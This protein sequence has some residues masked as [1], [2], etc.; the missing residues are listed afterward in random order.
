M[1]SPYAVTPP[2][3]TYLPHYE[4]HINGSDTESYY[5]TLHLIATEHEMPTRNTPDSNNQS[6]LS[7]R[8][9]LIIQ[10]NIEHSDKKNSWGNEHEARLQI[11]NAR[12]LAKYPR[13]SESKIEQLERWNE[14][15]NAKILELEDLLKE[16]GIE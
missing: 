10:K 4:Y 2:I 12:V 1:F 5:R 16:V 9:Q 14:Q 3:D 6:I 8:M 11:L 7:A 13:Y 15:E